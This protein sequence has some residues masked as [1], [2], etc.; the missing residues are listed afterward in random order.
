MIEC[1]RNRGNSKA[2]TPDGE[3]PLCI[4]YLPTRGDNTQIKT[5]LGSR[6]RGEVAVEL[7]AARKAFL[8]RL[9]IADVDPIMK[10][11]VNFQNNRRSA[12]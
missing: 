4:D 3:F 9:G 2:K 7:A 10:P 1:P 12:R 11:S 8:G 5:D 6:P